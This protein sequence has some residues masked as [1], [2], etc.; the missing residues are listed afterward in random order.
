MSMIKYETSGAVTCITLNR[1]EALNAFNGAMLE[2]FNQAVARFRDDPLLKAAVITGEGKRSFSAGADVK[3]MSVEFAGKAATMRPTL[4]LLR[5]D[6]CNKPLVAAIRGYCIGQGIALAL[7]CDLRV[8]ASDALFQV[9]EVAHGIPL[10]GLAA[11]IVKAVGPPAATELCLL[12]EKKDASW[13][14][15]HGLAH[16]VTVPGEELALAMQLAEKLGAMDS[17]SM[18]LS[19]QALDRAVDLSFD[20]V[21]A[22][23]EPLRKQVLAAG[24]AAQGLG[25]LSSK[26]T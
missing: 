26:Q 2:E 8:C 5:Q 15:A 10:G 12:G 16:R 17:A 14:L 11:Q 20:E 9:P 25:T 18:Q 6:Y 24:K 4:A 21:V 13:A 7:R 3:A 19:K 23:V 22:F 1:P